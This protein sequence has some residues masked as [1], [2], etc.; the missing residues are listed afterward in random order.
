MSQDGMCWVEGP[1]V[2]DTLQQQLRARPRRHEV[3]GGT[4]AV[5]TRPGCTA[6]G[7]LQN[8]PAKQETHILNQQYWPPTYQWLDDLNT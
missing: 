6:H 2:P 7:L 3:L 8:D 4:D 1:H 5:L